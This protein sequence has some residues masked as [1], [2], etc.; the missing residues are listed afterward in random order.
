MKKNVFSWLLMVVFAALIIFI[1]M[2][3]SNNK[4]GTEIPLTGS[5][6]TTTAV[7]NANV[8]LKFYV[9][10]RFYSKIDEKSGVAVTEYVFS[11]KPGE[12][13][14]KLDGTSFYIGTG[15]P[16]W[17]GVAEQLGAKG[18]SFSRGGVVLENKKIADS[19]DFAINRTSKLIL[20]DT[21]KN[22]IMDAF[23]T[24]NKM[25][26]NKTY[27]VIIPEKD[28][29]NSEEKRAICFGYQKFMAYNLYE[30]TDGGKDKKY[31]FTIFVPVINYD[32]SAKPEAVTQSYMVIDCLFAQP[33]LTQF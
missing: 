29:Q 33:I 25:D 30:N 11:P 23:A 19:I 1:F 17:R 20:Y 2:N 4:K 13:M 28:F 3:K 22:E 31:C 18:Q 6:E 15:S 9:P 16:V 14:K 26:L 10:Y 5:N 21:Y 24:Q 8:L 7:S 32:N 27:E 12:D